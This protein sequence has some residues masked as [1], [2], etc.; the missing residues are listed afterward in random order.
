MGGS[1]GRVEMM[2]KQ[3]RRLCG[4]FGRTCRNDEKARTATLGVSDR[5]VEMIRK[6][7]N[8]ADGSSVGARARNLGAS[9]H[10]EAWTLVIQGRTR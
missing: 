3:G 9:T 1:D 6:H 5:N 4:W 2:R 10:A 7:G 8:T